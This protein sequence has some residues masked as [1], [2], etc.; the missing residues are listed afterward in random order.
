M[1]VDAVSVEA[2]RKV[3]RRRVVVPPGAEVTR[4]FGAVTSR[5]GGV[6]PGCG[7]QPGVGGRA[8]LTT[9]TTQ[10]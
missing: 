1:N 6:N 4:V 9:N 8:P 5:V 3:A 7:G 10:T 2:N